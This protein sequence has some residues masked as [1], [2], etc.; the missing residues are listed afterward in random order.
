VSLGGGYVAGLVAVLAAELGQFAHC[1]AVFLVDPGEFQP[2]LA[3]GNVGGGVAA[4]DEHFEGFAAVGGEFLK[5]D[6]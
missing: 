6:L 4:G 2:E 3:L 5:G 1:R